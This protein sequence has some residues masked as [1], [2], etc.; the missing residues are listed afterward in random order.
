MADPTQEQLPEGLGE[1]V[2]VQWFQDWRIALGPLPSLCFILYKFWTTILAYSNK[3]VREDLGSNHR[4][5]VKR[6]VTPVAYSPTCLHLDD[7]R[8]GKGGP[9]VQDYPWLHG[10]FEASLGDMKPGLKKFLFLTVYNISIIGNKW[11][12]TILLL[13]CYCKL[14][15][16][17]S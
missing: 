3:N 12:Y 7:G 14:N 2:H 6:E 9:R 4:V 11:N 17:L 15:N 10:E 1:K 5:T 16:K 8:T 13:G